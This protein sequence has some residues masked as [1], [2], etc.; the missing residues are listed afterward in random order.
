MA[1]GLSVRT[2]VT[3]QLSNVYYKL[4]PQNKARHHEKIAMIRNEDPYALKKTEDVRSVR[5]LQHLESCPGP[6]MLHCLDISLVVK[7][8][9]V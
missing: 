4:E 7:M 8:L 6:P 9:V 3:V 2:V 5:C 1:K